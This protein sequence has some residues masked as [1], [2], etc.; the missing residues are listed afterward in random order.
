MSFRRVTS[1]R[2]HSDLPAEECFSRCAVVLPQGGHTGYH[3]ALLGEHRLALHQQPQT[4][5]KFFSVTCAGAEIPNESPLGRQA[6]GIHSEVSLRVLVRLY[7]WQA[8]LRAQTCNASADSQ[9]ADGGMVMRTDTSK[10]TDVYQA[11]MPMLVRARIS[12]PP[13]LHFNSGCMIPQGCIC[14][15]RHLLARTASILITTGASWPGQRH[16]NCD[17]GSSGKAV[18]HVIPVSVETSLPK[19]PAALPGIARLFLDMTATSRQH[20]QL[21]QL[22][23]ARCCR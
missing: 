9:V 2:H 5:G 8:E 7:G 15:F 14:R 19:Q 18:V 4:R 17:S 12:C 6:A 22:L 13:S 23:C 3:L 21:L 11:V 16:V 1:G 20:Q 10:S